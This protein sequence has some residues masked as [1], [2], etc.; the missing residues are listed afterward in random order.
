MSRSLSNYTFPLY[1]YLSAALPNLASGCFKERCLSRAGT[2]TPEVEFCG[3]PAGLD[4][5]EQ[6]SIAGEL[7]RLS[8][9]RTFH[10]QPGNETQPSGTT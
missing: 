8:A 3:T 6:L 10:R 9:V 4:F 1:W 5:K 2:L 7:V